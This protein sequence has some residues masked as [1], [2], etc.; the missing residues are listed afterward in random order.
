[1]LSSMIR[2]LLIYLWKS[3]ICQNKGLQGLIA[4]QGEADVEA[5]WSQKQGVHRLP[6]IEK[7]VDEVK[8]YEFEMKSKKSSICMPKILKFAS[9][10]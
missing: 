2:S 6:S 9:E 7:A 3:N 5:F 10:P 4:S 1:M 8:G